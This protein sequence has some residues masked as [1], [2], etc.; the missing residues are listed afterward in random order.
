[1]G[2][3]DVDESS[4]VRNVKKAL[5]TGWT[6]PTQDQIDVMFVGT[7]S[8]PWT[9]DTGFLQRFGETALRRRSND[10]RSRADLH[11]KP[12][13]PRTRAGR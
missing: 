9:T 3:R 5:L 11:G 2:N 4:T 12:G 7:T 13:D 10:R 1:M 6:K 8:R